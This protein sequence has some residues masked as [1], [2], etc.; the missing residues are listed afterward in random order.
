MIDDSRLPDRFWKKV[1]PEPMTGCWIWTGAT[2]GN[3]YG[4]FKIATGKWARSH[5]IAYAALVGDIA[6]GL[7][8]DHLCRVRSCVNPR[9]LEQV[10][11]AENVRRGVAARSAA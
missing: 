7:H 11:N 10:T 6:A 4:S 1:S 5:R 2:S 3:G 8:L 9:H